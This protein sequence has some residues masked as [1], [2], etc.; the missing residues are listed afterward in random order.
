MDYWE[1]NYGQD[2]GIR[3]VVLKKIVEDQVDR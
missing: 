2:P 1:R 3:D